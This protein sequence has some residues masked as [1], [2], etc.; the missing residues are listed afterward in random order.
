MLLLLAIVPAVMVCARCLQLIRINV[1]DIFREIYMWQLSNS[2]FIGDKTY[3]KI[4]P[5]QVNNMWIMLQSQY[6]VMLML[7]LLY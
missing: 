4:K 1:V 6:E 3:Y 5:E 2:D 7:L